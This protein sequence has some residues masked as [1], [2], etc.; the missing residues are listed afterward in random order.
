MSELGPQLERIVAAALEEDLGWGDV[1]SETLVPLDLRGQGYFLVKASGILAGMPAAAAVF[2]KVDP[3]VELETFFPEGSRVGPGTRVGVV[4]GRVI[5]LLKAERTA[6]NFLTHL[7]GVATLTAHYVEAVSGLPCTILDTRKTMPGLRFLDKYAVRMGGG[8]NHRLH[9]GDGVIIKDN[10]WAA[11]RR[12]GLSLKEA[13]ERLRRRLS[14]FI[15]IEVEVTDLEQ[16]REA[17]EA[18]ADIL[19]LDNMSLEEIKEAVALAKGKALLEAS[20]G[21]TLENA[22]SVAE[23]G[24]DFIS[25]GALTHSAP[26]LDISLELEF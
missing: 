2:R 10:H 4:R 13:L 9:L 24:V 11:L 7:S 23:A 6:L 1:T 21:I 8:R 15:K 18:G 17:L 20:G 22:R 26:A 25:V 19:M 12:A 5:S 16:V 3:E 14:P